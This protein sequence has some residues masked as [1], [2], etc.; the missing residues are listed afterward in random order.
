MLTFF[1]SINSCK[2]LLPKEAEVASNICGNVISF[3]NNLCLL[4]LISLLSSSERTSTIKYTR[5]CILH[6]S[7]AALQELSSESVM[8]RQVTSHRTRAEQ[9]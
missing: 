3:P 6:A 4:Q 5:V 2:E 7:P 8:H 1:E 9:R